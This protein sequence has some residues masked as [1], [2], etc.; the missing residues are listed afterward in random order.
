MEMRDNFGQVTRLGFSN[1]E[2]NLS[3]TTNQFKFIPPK[4][5]DVIGQ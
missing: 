5:V 3:L 4:D 1:V 2:K